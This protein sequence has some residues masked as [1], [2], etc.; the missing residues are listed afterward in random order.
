M[1]VGSVVRSMEWPD[2]LCGIGSCP[3]FSNAT[4]YADGLG[5]RV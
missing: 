4:A 2:E 5:F 3:D 1:R